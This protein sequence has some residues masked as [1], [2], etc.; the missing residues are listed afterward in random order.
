M[1]TIMQNSLA[2]YSPDYTYTRIP[3]QKEKRR[4]E[5]FVS[6]GAAV[7]PEKK[8]QKTRVKAVYVSESMV[9]YKINTGCSGKFLG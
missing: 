9:T 4:E 8:Q 7:D 2:L 6:R 5:T 1:V 3:V